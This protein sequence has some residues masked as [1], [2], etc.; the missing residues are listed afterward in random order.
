[1]IDRQFHVCFVRISPNTRLLTHVLQSDIEP[2]K[3][4]MLDKQSG[5]ARRRPFEM[6]FLLHQVSRGMSFSGLHSVCMA[7]GGSIVLMYIHVCS[8]MRGK[9]KGR[10]KRK[11]N[12]VL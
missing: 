8:Q 7:P 5:F 9:E 10:G 3:R 4:N 1:M 2:T 6:G 12:V 11:K